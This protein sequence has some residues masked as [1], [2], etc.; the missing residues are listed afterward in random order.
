MTLACEDGQGMEAHRVILASASPLF[1]RLLRRNKHAHPLI[2]LRGLI[3]HD[4]VQDSVKA[5]RGCLSASKYVC[6]SQLFLTII[7]QDHI[8]ACRPQIFNQLTVKIKPDG[9]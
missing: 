8:H 6:L 5:V 9:I 3:L 2:Y 1:Q 4:L 7:K